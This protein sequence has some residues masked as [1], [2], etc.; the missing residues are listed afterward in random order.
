MTDDVGDGSADKDDECDL[1]E[2]LDASFSND[3]VQRE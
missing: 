3:A 2:S 1:S